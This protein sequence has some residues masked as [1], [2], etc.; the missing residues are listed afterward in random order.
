MIIT[1]FKLNCIWSNL[2]KIFINISKLATLQHDEKNEFFFKKGKWKSISDDVRKTL[3]ILSSHFIYW[4][5][6]QW[7]EIQQ[8]LKY[9]KCFYK[10]SNNFSDIKR[11]RSAFNEKTSTFS[12]FINGNFTKPLIKLWPKLEFY[13]AKRY[14]LP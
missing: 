12:S 5:K 3:A 4:P 8:S 9:S 6:G 10:K 14:I 2:G 7:L 11:K 1:K 13:L